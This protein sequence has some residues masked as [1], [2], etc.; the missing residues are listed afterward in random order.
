MI[1]LISSHQ[2]ASC[3]LCVDIFSHMYYTSITYSCIALPFP[4]SHD[5]DDADDDDNNNINAHTDAHAL[6]T[7]QSRKKEYKPPGNNNKQ[8][9][10]L[11]EYEYRLN[12]YVHCA[13]TQDELILC[14]V[15]C[16]MSVVC[17]NERRR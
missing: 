12:G 15:K 7:I 9:K 17:K 13:R 2:S 3:V 8:Q 14:I 1:H 16:F 11:T 6:K 5:D 4:Y 10:H